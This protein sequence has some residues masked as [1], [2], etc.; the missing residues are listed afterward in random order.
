MGSA[1]VTPLA[2]AVKDKGNEGG[3]RRKAAE[4][5]GALGADA[6]P[7]VPTLVAAL[8]DPEVRTEAAKALGNMGP[9]AK[10]AAPALA[11]A[12]KAKGKD[13]AFKSAAAEAL[14]KVQK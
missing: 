2:K 6:Q 11:E 8:K 13:K 10:S 1:A 4:A 12:A 7:A 9:A 14:K 5:L 3:V